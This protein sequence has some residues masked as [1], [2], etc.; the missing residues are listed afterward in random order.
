[1]ITFPFFAHWKIIKIE[2]SFVMSLTFLSSSSLLV[3]SL[4]IACVISRRSCT[5]KYLCNDIARR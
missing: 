1:M 5:F 2:F 3:Y 4:F